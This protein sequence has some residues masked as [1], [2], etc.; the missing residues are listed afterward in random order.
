MATCQYGQWS[1]TVF[2]PCSGSGSALGGI[3]GLTSG[4]QCIVPLAVV[5]EFVEVFTLGL[6]SE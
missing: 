6:Q 2:Q 4:T 1:P 5:G 3:G